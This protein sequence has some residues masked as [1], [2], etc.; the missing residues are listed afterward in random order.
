[1]KVKLSEQSKL[2]SQ[3]ETKFNIGLWVTQKKETE[4]KKRC[5]ERAR[6]TPRVCLQVS[7]VNVLRM[8][9]FLIYARFFSFL[10]NE[11]PEA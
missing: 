1:M 5:R 4:E 7:F 6:Q 10:F 2:R 11:I 9:L 8:Q 3:E